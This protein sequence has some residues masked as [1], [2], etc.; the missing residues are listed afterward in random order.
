MDF[1][2]KK[3]VVELDVEKIQLRDP[4]QCPAKAPPAPA[5]SRSRSESRSSKK[6]LKKRVARKVPLD[7][8]SG[9]SRLA[10]NEKQLFNKV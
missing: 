10:C 6:S 9:R 7:S 2:R 3:S 5:P 4:K 8:Q 1:H